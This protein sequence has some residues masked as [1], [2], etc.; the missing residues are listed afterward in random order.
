MALKTM[1]K[2]KFMKE[3]YNKTNFGRLVQ[4]M[5]E[6]HP[7]SREMLEARGFVIG[8]QCASITASQQQVFLE[9]LG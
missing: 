9:I 8:S 5:L 3:Y 6:D 2:K 4:K 1:Y 7:E